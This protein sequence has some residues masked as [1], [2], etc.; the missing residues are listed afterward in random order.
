MNKFLIVLSFSTLIL[1]SC[2]N[3]VPYNQIA[4]GGAGQV[5]SGTSSQINY[6]SVSQQAAPTQNV[7]TMNPMDTQTKEIFRDRF[8]IIPGPG[9]IQFICIDRRITITITKW[10]KIPCPGDDIVVGGGGEQG[11]GSGSDG[12]TTVVPQSDVLTPENATHASNIDAAIGE[13]FYN[14]AVN[15][16]GSTLINIAWDPMNPAEPNPFEGDGL[17]LAAKQHIGQL[18]GQTVDIDTD[19]QWYKGPCPPFNGPGGGGGTPPTGGTGGWVI[20]GGVLV[21]P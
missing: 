15:F 6:L 10:I 18:I 1:S 17:P 9:F 2:K 4:M 7:L 3:V 12:H 20:P 13:G 21:G 11:S 8:M 19:E 14:P 5:A 16:Y